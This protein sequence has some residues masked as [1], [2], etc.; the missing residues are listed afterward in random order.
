MQQYQTDYTTSEQRQQQQQQQHPQPQS[1]ANHYNQG[2]MYNVPQQA[3]PT[4]YDAQQF[5]ARQPAAMQMLSDVAAPYFPG[6][7][8]NTAQAPGASVLHHQ[9]V[10]SASAGVYQQN[11]ADRSSLLQAYN[12]NNLA[13]MSGIPQNGAGPQPGPAEMMDDQQQPQT[14]FAPGSLED[15][16]DR[17]HTTLKGIFQNIRGGV[18]VEASQ[19]LLQVSDWL[20][21]NVGELGLTND[22]QD[23]HSDRINLW[24][25]FNTAWLAVLQKQ[26]DMT[27]ELL[28]TGHHPR[29]PQSM[30]ATDFLE[31]MGKDLV[32]FCDAIE[33]FG[34]VDYQYGVGEEDILHI[35][36]ECLDLLE[37]EDNNGSDPGVVVNQSSNTN[38]NLGR[39]AP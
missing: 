39:S 25:E 3:A 22:D 27:L 8:A 24:N 5:Q 30:I 19:S 11:P 38:M 4:V 34:L 26:K 14:E 18:L 13:N 17:Y 35:L 23:L 36:T 2:I 1:F 15:A 37:S 21:S 20:L 6:E 7:A 33:K 9:Q 12:P 31:R 29:H 16:Y 10:S 32:R 28:Q